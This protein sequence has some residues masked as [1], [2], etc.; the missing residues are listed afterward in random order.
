MQKTEEPTYEIFEDD[1]E[2]VPDDERPKR[3]KKRERR[4]P[5]MTT[6]CW[7]CGTRIKVYDDELP[8]D[9]IEEFIARGGCKWLEANDPQKSHAI[10]LAYFN[11][12]NGGG[13]EGSVSRKKN[14]RRR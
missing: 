12:I 2:Y 9:K 7:G 11:K 10:R 5:F 1:D 3:P 4:R 14:K 6:R 13:S 8:D